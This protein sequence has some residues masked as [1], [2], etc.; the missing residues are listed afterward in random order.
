MKTPRTCVIRARCTV[1]EK[2]TARRLAE[3]W[4]VDESDVLRIALRRLRK[5]KLFVA[6]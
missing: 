3:E 6:A 5:R 1:S 4:G 2:D